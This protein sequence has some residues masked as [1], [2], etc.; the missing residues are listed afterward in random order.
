[1]N[2]LLCS[3]LT[4]LY[5]MLPERVSGNGLS[6]VGREAAGRKACELVGCHCKS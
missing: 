6:Q 2:D 5:L 1:M 4:M 3:F